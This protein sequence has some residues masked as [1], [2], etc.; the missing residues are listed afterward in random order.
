MTRT[1]TGKQQRLHPE[2]IN[3]A[4]MK[5]SADIPRLRRTQEVLGL[6]Q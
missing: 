3:L 4:Q 6:A 1:L 2:A 5:L